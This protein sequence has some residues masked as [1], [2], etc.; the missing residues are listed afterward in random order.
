MDKK[1]VKFST[2]PFSFHLVF[3]VES[4]PDNYSI[5]LKTFLKMY[6]W[7]DH[8]KNSWQESN[9]YQFFF[10]KYFYLYLQRYS[11][12]TGPNEIA[13]GGRV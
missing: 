13:H 6:I 11:K 5:F 3:M 10:A 4:T 2:V 9:I 12:S 1:N 8:R 7:P